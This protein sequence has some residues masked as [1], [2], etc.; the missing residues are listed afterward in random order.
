MGDALILVGSGTACPRL[1]SVPGA[2]GPHPTAPR[3]GSKCPR[4]QPSLAAASRCRAGRGA[5]SRQRWDPPGAG[6][7]PTA[8]A[9]G[10]EQEGHPH[11]FSP[12]SPR[13]TPWGRVQDTGHSPALEC[14]TPEPSPGTARPLVPCSPFLGISRAPSSTGTWACDHVQGLS[15]G[16]RLLSATM[17]WS[18]GQEGGAR[19]TA[20]STGQVRGAGMTRAV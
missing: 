7:A 14:G 13:V 5:G 6:N 11:S 4:L 16:P 15:P 1:R 10:T 17:A 19:G 18:L 9:G 8:P 3:G 2:A 12:H 20:R